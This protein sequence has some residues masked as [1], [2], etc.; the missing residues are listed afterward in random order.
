MKVSSKGQPRASARTSC[1]SCFLAASLLTLFLL[2]RSLPDQGDCPAISL[3]SD[4]TF[5]N[6]GCS[7]EH[8]TFSGSISTDKTV[9]G[10]KIY[11]SSVSIRDSGVSCC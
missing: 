3:G 1:N 10:V 5:H 7:R 2:Y 6:N 8:G 11:G 4:I 9:S